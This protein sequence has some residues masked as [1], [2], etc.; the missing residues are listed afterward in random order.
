MKLPDDRNSGGRR[1]G[2]FLRL[3]FRDRR[4]QR[5]R[6]RLAMLGTEPSPAIHNQRTKKS[7]GNETKL[8]EKEICVIRVRGYFVVFHEVAAE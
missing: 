8:E 3:S 4:R 1:C 6:R 2:R 7:K 5:R